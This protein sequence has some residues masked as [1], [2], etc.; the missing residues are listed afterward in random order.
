MS[1]RRRLPSTNV[2]TPTQWPN[3][4]EL[5][6]V[7]AA[8]ESARDAI[9]ALRL[10]PANRRAWATSA[11]AAA[12]RAARASAAL[13]G[14]SPELD[15]AAAAIA[16]PVL[17]G[18]VRCNSAL[19]MLAP[20]FGR[21]P[22][23]ALARLHVLAA[24][25][26]PGADSGSRDVPVGAGLGRVRADGGQIAARLAGLAQVIT[27]APWPAPI[28][29]AVVHAELVVLRPFESG[30]GVVARAAARLTMIQSGLDVHALSVPEVSYLRTAVAGLDLLA[31]YGAGEPGAVGEWIRYVC[32]ALTAGA[33][34]GRS[35]ADAAS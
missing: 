33:G 15:S 14:G 27:S 2:K 19:A 18:A 25:D 34:E 12:I 7:A 3:L 31:A 8:V 29:V 10:H 11:A 35:I 4:V 17:A 6:G 26:L 32:R 16:D 28:T 23:Q 9:A 30:N 1:C 21:A 5:P 13:D 24:A 22:L 20:V